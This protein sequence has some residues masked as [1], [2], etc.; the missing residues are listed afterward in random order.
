[1][2]VLGE[3]RLCHVRTSL[4]KEEEFSRTE[5]NESGGAWKRD[6]RPPSVAVGGGGGR[7]GGGRG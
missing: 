3:K 1:M 2:A 4:S 5:L 6:G 7:G